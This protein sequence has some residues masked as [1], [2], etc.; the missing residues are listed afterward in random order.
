VRHVD[1]NEMKG[2]DGCD[3]GLFE[4]AK[5]AGFRLERLDDDDANRH[6]ANSPDRPESFETRADGPMPDLHWSRQRC[7]PTF[8]SQTTGF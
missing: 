4:S 7:R 5:A 1:E 2:L 6:S 8:V 3:G